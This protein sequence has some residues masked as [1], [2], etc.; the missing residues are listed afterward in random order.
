MS[1]GGRPARLGAGELSR[2]YVALLEG[3][4][5]HGFTTP[6]WTLKCVRLWR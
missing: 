3:P 2:L 5:R 4:E 1:K 6:L